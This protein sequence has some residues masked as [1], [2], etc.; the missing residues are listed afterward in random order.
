MQKVVTLLYP[1]LFLILFVS[2]FL[3]LPGRLVGQGTKNPEVDK[4]AA[5][6]LQT[7]GEAT[8]RTKP[9]HARIYLLVETIDDTVKE[10][11][12]QT[13]EKVKNVMS[14]I[15][16][17]KIGGLKITT[18]TVEMNPIH[19]KQKDGTKLPTILGYQC[20]QAFSVLVQSD[21]VD[22]LAASAS[23]VLDTALE[24]GANSVDKI[25]FF[26]S[27]LTD[28][29][30]EALTKASEDALGNA[31]A[32]VGGAKRKLADVLVMD[33]CS[34]GTPISVGGFNFNGGQAGQRGWEQTIV[35]GTVQVTCKVKL[36]CLHG[37]GK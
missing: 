14:A 7:E 17:L 29:K 21:D 3:P 12:K 13:I 8:V 36:T 23:R 26:R 28:L 9:D 34:Y 1:L 4:D 35:A 37:P 20:L 19:S 25:E 10:A 5:H 11:R 33:I 22:K 6:T 18:R 27:E 15:D 31:T 2:L 24:N 30:R 16:A 32:V